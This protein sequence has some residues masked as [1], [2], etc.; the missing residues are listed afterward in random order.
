[1]SKSHFA[2]RSATVPVVSVGGVSPPE[3]LAGGTPAALA[4]ED[5]CATQNEITPTFDAHCAL[6]PRIDEVCDKVRD[7]GS[8]AKLLRPESVYA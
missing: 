6:E 4:G 3:T 5:A 1:M 2:L 7:E 8:W